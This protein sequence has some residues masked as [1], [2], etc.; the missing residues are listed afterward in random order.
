M[1]LRWML[2]TFVIVGAGYRFLD[3]WRINQAARLTV[4]EL[5]NYD[6]IELLSLCLEENSVDFQ[7]G[8]I[9][10]YGERAYLYA[11]YN[12]LLQGECEQAVAAWENSLDLNSQN[13]ATLFRLGVLYVQLDEFEKAF[14]LFQRLDLA[15]RQK[16]PELLP[17][18]NMSMENKLKVFEISFW[19][20][21]S[22]TTVRRLDKTLT[23]AGRGNEKWFYYNELVAL[24]APDTFDHWWASGEIAYGQM[25]WQEAADAF[26]SGLAV[27]SE[28]SN[29]QW[30]YIGLANSF[31]QLG[32]D[33]CANYLRALVDSHV[34]HEPFTVDCKPE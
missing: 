34:Y 5:A 30:L 11:G 12:H 27:T 25:K 29:R 20:H 15:K 28:A 23:E 21:P 8:S 17:G 31:R 1:L 19:I 22:R 6:S 33:E 14:E 10:M 3:V 18:R 9:P 16:L 13:E 32:N 4:S 2:V 7:I 24:A 26:Y